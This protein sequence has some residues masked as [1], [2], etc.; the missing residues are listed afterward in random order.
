MAVSVEELLNVHKILRRKLKARE[1]SA[2]LGVSR[3]KTSKFLDH[4]NIH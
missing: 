1:Q 4:K 2:H 3:E